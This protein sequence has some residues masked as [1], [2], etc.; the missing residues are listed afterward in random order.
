MIGDLAG[1][2]LP[3]V[4]DELVEGLISGPI[5][6]KK[7]SAITVLLQAG[8][9]SD[10]CIELIGGSDEGEIFV[11]GWAQ[12]L[13]PAVTRLLISGKIHP[14]RSARSASLHGPT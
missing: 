5:S 3:G 8:A 10:G 9:R 11:Q 14:S 6:R 2:S 7:L 13:T 12:D 1:P 4:I